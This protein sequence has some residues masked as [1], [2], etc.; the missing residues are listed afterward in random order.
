MFLRRTDEPRRKAENLVRAGSELAGAAVGGALGFFAG[1]PAAAASAAVGG[2][3][4]ARL[5][6]SIGSEI[7]DRGLG[8]RE[9][10]RAGAAAAVAADHIQNRLERGDQPREDGFFEAKAGARSGAEELAEGV[11]LKSRDSYQEKKVQ[12]LG[13]FL[14][15][16]VFHSE[17]SS[18][19]ANFFLGLFDHLTFRQLC[20]LA[21]FAESAP[22]AV[23]AVSLDGAQATVEEWALLQEIDS[24]VQLSLARQVD[25]EGKLDLYWGL[26]A[27]RPRSIKLTRNGV[28]MV[29]YFHL[30]LLPWDELEHCFLPFRARKE[31]S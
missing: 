21:A 17:L 20:L 15:N 8:P 24:L 18:E 29:E 26:G 9:R 31:D 30:R 11:L 5:L 22:V 10:L 27:I 1:G 13:Y 28:D 6:I 2:N 4:L 3:F 14:A 23:P 25:E 12:Y 19:R 16:A 7:Q